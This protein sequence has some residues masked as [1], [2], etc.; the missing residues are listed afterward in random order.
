MLGKFITK[1]QIA[2]FTSKP[3][4]PLV[5]LK[6]L[7]TTDSLLAFFEATKEISYHTP[8]DVL[9]NTEETALL[10]SLHND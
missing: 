5:D 8:W 4:C 6:K 10:S 7:D 1:A 2:Y 3:S 9:L